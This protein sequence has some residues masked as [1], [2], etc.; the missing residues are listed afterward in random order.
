MTLRDLLWALIAAVAA[1]ALAVAFT[2]MFWPAALA[3]DVVRIV[4]GVSAMVIAATLTIRVCRR[5]RSQGQRWAS[6]VQPG[7]AASDTEQ[8]GRLWPAPARPPQA[9]V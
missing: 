6:V 3:D 5:R 2:A 1:A 9:L 8:V 7:I 4:L